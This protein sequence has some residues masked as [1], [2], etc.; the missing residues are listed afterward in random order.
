MSE[1][2]SNGVPGMTE[3]NAAEHNLH[4]RID[5]QDTLLHEVRD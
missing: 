5:T 2:T 4:R 3:P 1:T